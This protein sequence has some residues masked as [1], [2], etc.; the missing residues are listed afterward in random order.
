[1]H[2]ALADS[3]VF[4]IGDEDCFAIDPLNERIRQPV[5][6]RGLTFR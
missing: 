1:M 2:N 3:S 5:A 6:D 4:T